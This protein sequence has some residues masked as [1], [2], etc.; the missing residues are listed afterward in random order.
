MNN[1][2]GTAPVSVHTEII[3][4]AEPYFMYFEF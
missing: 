4:S 3:K 2:V 1:N